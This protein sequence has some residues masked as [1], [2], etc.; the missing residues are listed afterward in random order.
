MDE[1]QADAG[2]VGATCTTASVDIDGSFVREVI[3]DN[4]C[5]IADVDTTSCHVCRNQ[6]LEITLTEVIHHQ[7]ALSL[8]KVAMQ[9]GC[10]ISIVDKII[11][12]W[13]ER[14]VKTPMDIQ[15]EKAKWQEERDKK[16]P[17]KNA[18]K[19]TTALNDEPSY[20]ISAFTKKAIG[21]KYK[22]TTD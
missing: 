18:P 19:N 8:R 3:I 12:N 16:L 21:L 1:T 22:K 11:R 5:K 2:L 17:Q 15:R 4:M 7:V 14:G 20:D 13:H 9:R 6:D 10:I